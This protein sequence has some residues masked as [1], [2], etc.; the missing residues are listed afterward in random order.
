MSDDA[1]HSR[2]SHAERRAETIELI[3]NATLD[4]IVELGLRNATTGEICRRAGVSPGAVFHHFETRQD[5]IVAA[6]EHHLSHRRVRFNEMVESLRSRDAEMVDPRELLR[7]LRSITR[8]PRAMVWLE[9]LM[10]TRTDSEL[11]KRITPTLIR[12]RDLFRAAGELHSWAVVDA[13]KR[14]IRLARV[15]PQR[16]ARRIDLGATR[17]A[18]RTG[19]TEDRR[20][21]R[22]RRAPRSNAPAG[23]R[24]IVWLSGSDR[25]RVNS[26]LLVHRNARLAFP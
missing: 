4:A 8:E 16:H 10:E 6:V 1:A 19:G 17:P 11:R 12:Q 25:W 13:G 18:P 2:R 22:A 21:A 24:F 7:I 5:V 14:E 9:V 20:P 15:A 3:L 26:R 23:T